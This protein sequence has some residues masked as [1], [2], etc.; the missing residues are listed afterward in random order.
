LGKVD[1]VILRI[2]ADTSGAQGGKGGTVR[3]VTDCMT[4]RQS[5][6][7]EQ[8]ISARKTLKNPC[9]KEGESG[10]ML[11]SGYSEI[12]ASIGLPIGQVQNTNCQLYGSS[13]ENVRDSR[14]G[15]KE[16]RE[17]GM[18]MEDRMLEGCPGSPSF[19]WGSFPNKKKGN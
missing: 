9:S 10:G 18:P 14:R 13:Q 4:I 5:E 2:T 7:R 11:L 12:G 17:K 16:K 1:V 6:Y 8:I 19:C 15:C 3:N